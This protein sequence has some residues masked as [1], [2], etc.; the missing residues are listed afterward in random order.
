M[1]IVTE[2]R[3]SNAHAPHPLIVH[4]IFHSPMSKR[5][6]E[7]VTVWLQ[8]DCS[9]SFQVF[10]ALGPGTGCNAIP[11]AAS[12][13]AGTMVLPHIIDIIT[14]HTCTMLLYAI[15]IWPAIITSDFWTF[16]VEHTIQLHNMRPIADHNNKCPYE[17]PLE[18]HHLTMCP[19]FSSKNGKPDPVVS[20][21]DILNIMLAR[22]RLFRTLS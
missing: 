22:P 11:Y 14:N 12:A 21:L 18:R 3:G 19:T 2:C 7:L 10:H 4:V 9:S 17:F 1:V 16:A 20:T 15:I 5:L 8:V 6:I 13:L